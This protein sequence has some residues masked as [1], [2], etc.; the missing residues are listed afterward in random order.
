MSWLVLSAVPAHLSSIL[1]SGSEM[2]VHLTP[3]VRVPVLFQNWVICTAVLMPARPS[4]LL[5]LPLCDL[6][7]CFLIKW[8]CSHDPQLLQLV[9]LSSPREDRLLASVPAH[10]TPCHSFPSLT[11]SQVNCVPITQP[12]SIIDPPRVSTSP[13]LREACLSGGSL[14]PTS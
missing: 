10:P 5:T 7:S 3:C 8:F 6:D 2:S 9:L 12:A 1:S 14:L 4:H 11:F 13:E